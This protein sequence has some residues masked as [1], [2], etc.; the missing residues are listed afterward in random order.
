MASLV[1]SG[2]SRAKS[3]AA[4][5]QV[6]VIEHRPSKHLSRAHRLQTKCDVRDTYPAPCHRCS[7]RSLECRMDPDFQR[8]NTRQVQNRSSSRATTGAVQGQVSH[9]AS[10][11]MNSVST[12]SPNVNGSDQ[13]HRP[14]VSHE[15]IGH[16]IRPSAPEKWLQL[17]LPNNEECSLSWYLA[18]VE[19]TGDVIVDLLEQ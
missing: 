7:A 16:P 5:R 4:C 1:T 12:V 17:P 9:L 3:C 13:S 8:V 11:P 19:V 10:R 2:K 6:K 18:P 14:V 15:A